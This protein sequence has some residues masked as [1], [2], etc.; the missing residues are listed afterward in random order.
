LGLA[1]LAAPVVSEGPANGPPI[2][3]PSGWGRVED[4]GRPKARPS[5]MA[6]VSNT[7]QTVK[8]RTAIVA[9]GQPA[10]P[11]RDDAKAGHE[12]THGKTTE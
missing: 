2:A 3:R 10:S 12:H 11:T 7:A 1:Q 9:V 5:A 4:I 6:E 8:P